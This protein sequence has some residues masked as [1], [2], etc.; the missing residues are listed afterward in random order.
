MDKSKARE[1]WFF[2]IPT[3]DWDRM[4]FEVFAKN[5]LVSI[6]SS[7]E[8]ANKKLEELWNKYQ[9]EEYVDLPF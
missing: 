1:N 5:E 2:I 3:D 8:E 4:L 6:C 7:S 9:D